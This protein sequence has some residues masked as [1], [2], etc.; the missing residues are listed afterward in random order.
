M[1]NI[2]KVLVVCTG[3]SCRS[4]MAEAY[5]RKRFAEEGLDIEVKSAGTLGVSGMPPTPEA[6]RMLSLE[7]VVTDNLESKSLKQESVK[8]ADIVLVMEPMHK[9]KAIEM[10][11]SAQGKVFYLGQFN[12]EG[13]D[14]VI[15][16][17][18]GRPLAFYRAAFRLIR[19]STEG[20][21]EWLKKPDK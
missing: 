12:P 9:N 18:I 13:G 3:N 1:K 5:M 6:L 16:D 14:I 15:P 17:P 2:H 4:I 8:D 7:G 19:Q 11:P 21:I 10:V 20:F